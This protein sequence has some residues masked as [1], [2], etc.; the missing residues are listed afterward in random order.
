[1]QWQLVGVVRKPAVQG[2]QDFVHYVELQNCLAAC[3]ADP[4]FFSHCLFFLPAINCLASARIFFL[5]CLLLSLPLL[6]YVVTCFV[7]FTSSNAL[8]DLMQRFHVGHATTMAFGK[9]Q[10]LNSAEKPRSPSTPSSSHC[11]RSKPHT[12]FFPLPNCH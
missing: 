7:L 6:C 1:M 12:A 4:R 9:E 3:A 5:A 11:R 2:R 10:T 8:S